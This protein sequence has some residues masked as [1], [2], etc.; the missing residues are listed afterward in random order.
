MTRFFTPRLL[1]ATALPALLLAT[2]C[3]P[4]ASRVPGYLTTPKGQLLRNDAGQC[5]RTVEWR[6][7]LARVEC[8]P[9]IVAQQL[10]LAQAEEEAPPEEV[11]QEEEKKEE[12]VLRPRGKRYAGLAGHDFVPNQ[13]PDA[14]LPVVSGREVVGADGKTRTEIVFAPLNLSSDTSFRFGDDRLTPEGRDALI[15]LAGTLKRRR[16]QGISIDIVGHTDRIGS[17]S[18]NLALSRRR[19]EAVKTLLVQE[20]IPGAGIRTAGMG[21]SKP[22][23]DRADCPDDLVKCELI[24][25]LRPDR[26]VEI[27]IKAQVDSGKRTTVPVEATVPAETPAPAGTPQS[28]HRPDDGR[29]QVRAHD[30]G[31]ICRA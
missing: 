19:A 15:E 10:A 1:L 23:T 9:E 28:L 30:S 21:A 13:F 5:W 29:R 25:C 20:G 24:E 14:E 3:T 7:S 27:R 8:D 26:R 17:A 11:A 18:A 12:E 16:A 22:V 31:E 6:P 2:A 4:V